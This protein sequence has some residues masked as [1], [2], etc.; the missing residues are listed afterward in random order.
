MIHRTYAIVSFLLITLLIGGCGSSDVVQD[1][2]ADARFEIAKKKFDDGDYLE[3]ISDFEIIR[4]Q[5]PASGVADDAQ[6]YI[7]ESRF[8][9]GEY[10]I[11]AEEYQALRR[12][13]PSSSFGPEAQYKIGLSYYNVSPRSEL[14]QRNSERAI[15]EF[16]TFIEYNPRH[17][18][19]PDA[20]AK[21]SELNDKLAKKQYD[22][23]LLY[24]KLE[25]YKSA[26]IYFE[27][28]IERYH[29]SQYA[30]PAHFGKIESLMA[31]KRF[32]EALEET[33]RYIDRFPQSRRLKQVESMRRDIEDR[34]KA[35]GSAMIRSVPPR[36]LDTALFA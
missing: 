16:Q 8:K 34:L 24:M 35:R 13:Y 4:L 23:A 1:L 36:V 5:Y 3:A 9:R 21:I 10:L 14:D 29:D 20:E 17:E 30:E 15:D 11:A 28:V 25:D 18:L 6:F 7:A 12:N 26:T 31:R 32:A 2:S 33:Q 22:T 19:V 27:N